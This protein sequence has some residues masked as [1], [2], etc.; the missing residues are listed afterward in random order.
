MDL[1]FAVHKLEKFS[2]KPGKVHFGGLVHL[3]R[4]IKENK[5]LVLKYYDYMNDAP[6][7]DLLRQAIIDT[8]RK[9]IA[10]YGCTYTGRS[11]GAYIIFYQGG[12]IDHGVHVPGPVSKSSA[13]RKYNAA[14]TAGMALAHFRML[15]NELLNKYPDIVPYESPLIILYGKFSVCM[16]NNGNNTNQTRHI[17]RRVHFI[18]NVENLKMNKID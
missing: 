11:T 6:V 9:F 2:S 15:L 5:T 7:S 4:E 1:I 8:E 12:T 13:V 14:C 17:Y 10:F 3:L 18:R 16:A